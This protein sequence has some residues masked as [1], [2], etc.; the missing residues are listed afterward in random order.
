MPASKVRVLIA[1]DNRPFAEVLQAMLTR[2]P[3]MEVVGLVTS[4]REAVELAGRLR[5]DLVLMDIS[6]PS[7][8]GLEATRRIR[9]QYQDVGVL[10]VTGSDA[11]ADVDAARQA[12]AA[13]YLTKDNIVGGLVEAILDAARR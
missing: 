11:A 7:V 8:D 10:I 3:R 5:P 6:M 4:G 9:R 1:D 2:D 13:G 12:G